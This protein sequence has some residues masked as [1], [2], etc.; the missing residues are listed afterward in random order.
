MN[1]RHPLMSI[2]LSSALPWLRVFTVWRCCRKKL[3]A[4]VGIT[5]LPTV[6]VKDQEKRE[7]IDPLSDSSQ[8]SDGSHYLMN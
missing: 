8:E 5:R 4:E 3:D 7:A 1:R 6:V 2:P